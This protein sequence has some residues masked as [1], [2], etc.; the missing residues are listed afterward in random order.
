MKNKTKAA[1]SAAFVPVLLMLTSAY[2]GEY[3]VTLFIA[4]LVMAVISGLFT[5]HYLYKG[6]KK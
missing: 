5:G 1:I 6:D 4:I 2:Y 3:Y